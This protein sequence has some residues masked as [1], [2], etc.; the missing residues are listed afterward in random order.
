MLEHTKIRSPAVQ[1]VSFLEGL[2][3]FIL[4]LSYK[5]SSQI[6]QFLMFFHCFCGNAG[7]KVIVPFI[8]SE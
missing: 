5:N 8:L 7:I 3:Y 4:P 6:K 1:I 2:L